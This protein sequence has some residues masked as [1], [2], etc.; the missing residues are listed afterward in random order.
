MDERIR[1]LPDAE[2]AVM[3]ALW[4]CGGS[5]RRA[6]I[7]AELSS[8][9]PMA[10]TT[11]LT[12]LSRLAE[13]GFLRIEKEGRSALYTPCVTR[14]S[15]LARQSRRFYDQ[16]CGGSLPAFAAALCGSGLSREELAELR[17]LLAEDTL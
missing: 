10:P 15:Y 17:R 1:S 12:V 2:L 3:Q 4:A 8:T 7:D 16:L 14:Q 6:Q 13:K 9:H 5:A 11:L